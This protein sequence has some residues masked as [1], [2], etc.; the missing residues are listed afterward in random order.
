MYSGTATLFGYTHDEVLEYFPGRIHQLAAA[1]GLTDEDAF[2]KIVEWYDGY[3]FEEN[4]Q[5]VINPVSLGLCFENGKF[6]NYWSRTAMPTFLVDIL[7][8]R[9][10][11]FS[12]VDIDE[13]D[14]GN[15]EPANPKGVTLLFQTGY[16]T[17]DKFVQMGT[18][19]RYTLRLPN[20]EVENSFLKDVVGA[21]TGRD[22]S[23]TSGFAFTA[24]EALYS[25]DVPR[26]PKS[27]SPLSAFR[28]PPKSAR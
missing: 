11:D 10:L 4:A 16:L 2:A 25:H 6:A 12:R 5:P 13:D 1:Q 18:S 28:F 27:A 3:K 14:L 21:Y 7:K 19:R 15:Y 8:S 23:L 17:I 20:L 26:F 22:T 24:G 9:P